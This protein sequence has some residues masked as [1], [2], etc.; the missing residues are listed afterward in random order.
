MNQPR[1]AKKKSN[2]PAK[3]DPNMKPSAPADQPEG[4]EEEQEEGGTQFL[5]FNVIPSWMVSSLAHIA[6]II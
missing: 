2:V 1:P 5:L 3:K 4:E 6:V